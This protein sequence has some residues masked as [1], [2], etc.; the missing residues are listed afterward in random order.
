MH[1]VRRVPVHTAVYDMVGRD[2][3]TRGC[4]YDIINNAVYTPGVV[5]RLIPASLCGAPPRLFGVNQLERTAEGTQ[6]LVLLYI[7]DRARMSY[8]R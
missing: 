6:V 2:L 3:C 4:T 1:H 7:G 8:L 5:D